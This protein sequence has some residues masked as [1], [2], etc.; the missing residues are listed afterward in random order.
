MKLDNKNPPVSVMFG[1]IEFRRM[2]GSCN[3]YLSYSRN[4]KDRKGAKGLHVVIWEHHSGSNVPDG[5]EIHHVDGDTFNCEF[6]NLE[7]I[8]KSIHRSLPK[9]LDMD[10]V[11]ENL[12][13]IRPKASE[14]HRSEE[15]RA[16]HREHAKTIAAKIFYERECSCIECGKKFTAKKKAKYCGSL[17]GNRARAKVKARVYKNENICCNCEKAFAGQR[18]DSKYCSRICYY[19]SLK[20]NHERQRNS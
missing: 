8:S 6:S 11:R 15:G 13:R 18:P 12:A 10:K 4:Y 9:K 5:Y 20:D 14:W 19:E 17:C 16:W 2:G 3:Y 1:G 7:C